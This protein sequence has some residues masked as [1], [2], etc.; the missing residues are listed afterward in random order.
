MTMFLNRMEPYRLVEYMS[1]ESGLPEAR[2]FASRD[3][4]SRTAS[5]RHERASA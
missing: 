5:I 2:L 4:S 3:T 1:E